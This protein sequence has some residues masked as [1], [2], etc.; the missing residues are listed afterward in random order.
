MKKFLF[1][2]CFIY[3]S[4]VQGQYDKNVERLQTQLGL[5]VPGVLFETAVYKNTT[6][7]IEAVA[8]FP[9]QGLTVSKANFNL[10]PVVRGQ[11]R[12]YHNMGRRLGKKK[13]ISGNSG[14][15]IAAL[16]AYQHGHPLIGNGFT[17]TAL[18]AG[19]V[20]GIQ[21]TFGRDLFY[22]LEGGVAYVQNDVEEGLGLVLAARVGWVFRKKERM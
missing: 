21:R 19:P 14:N 2:T 7:S 20:Y 22:R 10:Y 15:Y 9:L 17:G 16:L 8:D 18:A 11:F 3:F 12:Y 13:N 6:T 5:L 4:L 1:F